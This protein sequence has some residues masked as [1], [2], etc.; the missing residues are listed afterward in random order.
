MKRYLISLWVISLM[1][2]L[3][4]CEDSPGQVFGEYDTSKLSNDFNQNNEA[5][6]IGANKDGM[7]IF[8]DTNKAF[9]Q[10]LIDYENGFIAIQEEFNLDPVNSENWESYKIFGWQL[11]TD[12]ESIRKQGSEITQFFDIYENSFK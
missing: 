12:V 10:A 7:P 5:Y 3:A 8:K 1:L 9:E 4:A 11:T 2:F 6:S